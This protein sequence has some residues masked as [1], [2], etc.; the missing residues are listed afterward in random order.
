MRVTQMRPE[1]NEMR[2]VLPRRK[3]GR[4]P[5]ATR[6]SACGSSANQ[7][8]GPLTESN[9]NGTSQ[10]A[11]DDWCAGRDAGI[12]RLIEAHRRRGEILR[13]QP[14]RAANAGQLKD[15][16]PPSR[17]TTGNTRRG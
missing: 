11:C 14:C 16:D 10:I 4:S 1:P 7:E 2:S 12:E 3:R 6:P 8:G 17:K 5:T 13:G 9:R 15:G